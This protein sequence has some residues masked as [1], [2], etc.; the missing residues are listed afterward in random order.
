V[1]AQPI[2]GF[3]SQ[4]VG[5]VV[6]A[7]R[8]DSVLLSLFPGALRVFALTMIAALALAI[9]SALRMRQIAVPGRA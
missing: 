3:D 1:L 4:I 7:R 2:R 8:I 6:M 9:A 5:D